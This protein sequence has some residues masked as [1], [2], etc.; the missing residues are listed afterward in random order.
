MNFETKAVPPDSFY[1]DDKV[2]E[3]KELDTPFG[4][5]RILHLDYVAER[6]M[7]IPGFILPEQP[8]Q[9]VAEFIDGHYKGLNIGYGNKDEY[10]LDFHQ[11]LRL[12]F[13]QMGRHVATAI[14]DNQR[15]TFDC[16]NWYKP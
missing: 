13:D 5:V 16:L 4:R 6:P 14:E 11:A 9:L 15:D 2:L 7:L 3:W 8:E 12:L 1:S 10:T